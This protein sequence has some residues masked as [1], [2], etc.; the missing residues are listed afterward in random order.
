MRCRG[1]GA[2]IQRKEPGL[3]ELQGFWDP[4]LGEARKGAAMGGR[5]PGGNEGLDLDLLVPESQ[6]ELETGCLMKSTSS[7]SLG[8][9]SAQAIPNIPSSCELPGPAPPSP[10]LDLLS[11][12]CAVRQ[13]WTAQSMTLPAFTSPLQPPWL[14]VS[15]TTALSG[16]L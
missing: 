8:S 13:L 11:Q 2:K 6:K 3:W 16:S 5:D 12:S 9:L 14:G 10:S 1:R 7:S 15:V 4:G